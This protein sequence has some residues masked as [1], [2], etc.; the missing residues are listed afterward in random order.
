MT[1]KEQYFFPRT[2]GF[3][4][5]LF[6]VLS[7]GKKNPWISLFPNVE[8]KPYKHYLGIPDSSVHVP[9]LPKDSLGNY[10]KGLGSEDP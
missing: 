6:L 4:C 1:L 3:L 5:L 9:N 10:T 8:S 7:C 2:A